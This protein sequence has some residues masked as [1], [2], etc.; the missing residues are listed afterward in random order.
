MLGLGTNPVLNVVET[1]NKLQQL[2]TLEDYID[3]FENL[4]SIML[5]NNHILHDTYM[6]ESFI[7]GLKPAVKPFVKAFKPTTIAEA[8]DLARLQEENLEAFTHKTHK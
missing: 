4:R 6:L 5:K 1:F 2:S 8:I 3:E 7:G